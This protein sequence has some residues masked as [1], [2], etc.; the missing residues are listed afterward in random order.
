M[1][2][3]SALFTDASPTAPIRA[4]ARSACLVRAP[5]TLPPRISIRSVY[6]AGA[7][8]FR[9]SAPSACLVRAPSTLPLRTGA[10]CTFPAPD[11]HPNSPSLL[12]PSPPRVYHQRD[13]HPPAP[14]LRTTFHHKSATYT[15]HHHANVARVRNLHHASPRK[16]RTSIRSAYLAGETFTLL[17][18]EK[19]PTRVVPPAHVPYLSDVTHSLPSP[20]SSPPCKLIPFLFRL[21]HIHFLRILKSPALLLAPSPPPLSPSALTCTS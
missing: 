10:A 9:A 18:P 12:T 16:R 5:C 7:T 21:R 17:S 6:L 11:K 2:N 13:L 19:Y 20:C 15:I 1:C 3:C 4:D 8:P 14:F